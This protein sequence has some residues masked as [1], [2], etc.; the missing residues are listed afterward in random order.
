M[1][2][3][4]STCDNALREQGEVGKAKTQQ[5]KDTTKLAR[6]IRALQQPCGLNRFDAERFGDHCLNTTVARIRESFGS[7]LQSRWETVPSRF[8]GNGVRVL[9]YWITP[10][11]KEVA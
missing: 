3:P 2:K 1:E 4:N 10:S 9:R 7:R 5:S 11:D 8:T 6:I